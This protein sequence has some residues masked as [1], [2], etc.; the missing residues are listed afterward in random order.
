M[1]HF[2]YML[3]V[4]EVVP[5][6]VSLDLGY[7]NLLVWSTYLHIDDCWW[8]S[9]HCSVCVTFLLDCWVV[10]FVTLNFTGLMLWNFSLWI[11]VPTSIS[12]CPCG[13]QLAVRILGYSTD[14]NNAWNVAK[15]LVN[16]AVSS[17][18]HFLTPL[19]LCSAHLDLYVCWCQSDN[20]QRSVTQ[21]SCARSYCRSIKLRKLLYPWESASEI[22]SMIEYQEMTADR[23]PAGQ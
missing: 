2:S 23:K 9:R 19:E 16:K 17:N 10:L 4:L 3:A 22:Q 5:W 13:A 12:E 20:T 1:I 8:K 21:Y 11:L 15:W 18:V 6:H 7:P 14:A